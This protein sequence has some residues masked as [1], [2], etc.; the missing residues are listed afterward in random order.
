MDTFNQDFAN[1]LNDELHT[2]ERAISSLAKLA[3]DH[4]RTPMQWSSTEKN[5]G[6][7]TADKTWC[8]M[9]MRPRTMLMITFIGCVSLTTASA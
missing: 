9:P 8:V 4:N 6:F 7:S 2:K 1:G 3:R 5:A